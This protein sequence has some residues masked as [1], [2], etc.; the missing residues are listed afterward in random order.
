MVEWSWEGKLWICDESSE[1]ITKLELMGWIE[2]MEKGVGNM[3][4][5][6]RER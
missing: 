6:E 4:A 1:D 2:G 3:Q 5:K